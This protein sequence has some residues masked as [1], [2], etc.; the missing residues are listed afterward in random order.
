MITCKTSVYWVIQ[1]FLSNIGTFYYKM[2]KKRICWHNLSY[3]RSIVKFL[4]VWAWIHIFQNSYFLLESSNFVI[5][6]KYWRQLVFLEV[7][8]SLNS[9]LR[10]CLHHI[11][12]CIIIVYQ[13]FFQGKW[14]SMTKV[15]CS[16]DNWVIQVLFLETTVILDMK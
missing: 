15:A 3:Q 12:V 1:T 2:S 4:R 14:C 5:C 13:L 7:T 8:G 9:F 6:N 11:Q 10:K 16:A